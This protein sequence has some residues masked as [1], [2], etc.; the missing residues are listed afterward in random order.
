M[1]LT[2][3]KAAGLKRLTVEVLCKAMQSTAENPLLGVEG[4]ANLLQGLGDSLLSFPDI[5][6]EIGRPGNLVGELNQ[7]DWL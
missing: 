1:Y 3:H 7:I 5:F 6:G 4:R 2:R